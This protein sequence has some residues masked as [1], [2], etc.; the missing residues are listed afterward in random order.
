[1]IGAAVHD[2]ERPHGTVNRRSAK[3]FLSR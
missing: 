2:P 1:M 3:G